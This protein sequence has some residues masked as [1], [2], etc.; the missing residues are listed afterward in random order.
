M[1]RMGSIMFIWIMYITLI[2]SNILTGIV[3]YEF[4]K[5]KREDILLDSELN[6]EGY[7]LR[8]KGWLKNVE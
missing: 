3:C 1:G 8:E 4:G 5:M 6:N 7:I 2:V